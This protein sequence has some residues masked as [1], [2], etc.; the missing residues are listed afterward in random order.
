VQ[1]LELELETIHN[2]EIYYK[3]IDCKEARK[4][5]ICVYIYI[6]IYIYISPVI[7]MMNIGVKPKTGPAWPMAMPAWPMA[8]ACKNWCG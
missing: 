8:M 5:Y 7:T 6:Y 3:T 2:K 1:E 4:A